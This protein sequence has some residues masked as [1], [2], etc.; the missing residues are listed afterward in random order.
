MNRADKE[1]IVLILT[2]KTLMTKSRQIEIFC[3]LPRISALVQTNVTE[4]L[5]EIEK[6]KLNFYQV[7]LF[8]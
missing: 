5:Y 3:R 8:E 1:A 2:C 7:L 6:E 4:I